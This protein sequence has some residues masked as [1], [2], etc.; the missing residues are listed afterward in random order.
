MKQILVDTNILID[1]LK[2]PT[3]DATKIFEQNE[4]ATCGVIV[5]ELLRGSKSPKESEKLKTALECFEYLDFEKADWIEI[6]EL[7]AKLYK[8]TENNYIPRSHYVEYGFQKI[9]KNFSYPV[10][11]KFI[12]SEEDSTEENTDIFE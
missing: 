8:L 10:N 11:E 1:Y 9:G 6:A 2:N 5:T 12:T 7:F 4:I 3:E